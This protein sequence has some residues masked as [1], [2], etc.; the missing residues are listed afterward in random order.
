MVLDTFMMWSGNTSHS[1]G[2][3]GPGVPKEEGVTGVGAT[4]AERTVRGTDGYEF[5]E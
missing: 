1:R 2:G 3:G 4:H 5:S